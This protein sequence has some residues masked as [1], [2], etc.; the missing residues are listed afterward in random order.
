M[1]IAVDFDGTIVEH[2]YPGIGKEI[3]F[4]FETLR[5]FQA[6]GHKLVLWTVREGE[7]LDA[8]V[9]YCRKH[10]VEFYAI[11]SE[12]PGAAWSGS[13]VAR[14]LKADVYID[15]RSVGGIPDWST[16]YDMVSGHLTFNDIIAKVAAGEALPS[17]FD[18]YNGTFNR[19]HRHHHKRKSLLRRIIDRCRRSREKLTFR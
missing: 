19:P 1:T 10:G 7:L 6:N 17:T 12:Y 16:I 11:N 2:K 4:A 3:P 8:A 9:A 13:G 14:K 18:V 15:D 5:R